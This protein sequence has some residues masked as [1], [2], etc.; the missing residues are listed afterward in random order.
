MTHLRRLPKKKGFPVRD[1]DGYA[2][3]ARLGEGEDYIGVLDIWMSWKL[4]IRRDGTVIP[5]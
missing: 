2:L 3:D 4:G 5:S 1:F